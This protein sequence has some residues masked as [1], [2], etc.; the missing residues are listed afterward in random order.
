[1]AMLTT[2]A[3]TTSLPLPDLPVLTPAPEPLVLS[4]CVMFTG[5]SFADA[6]IAAASASVSEAA[7]PGAELTGGEGAPFAGAD[8]V[9][10][11]N[12]AA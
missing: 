1:M 5:G 3:M 11:G 6:S 10:G 12:G 2:T 9:V 4:F 7:P 8:G